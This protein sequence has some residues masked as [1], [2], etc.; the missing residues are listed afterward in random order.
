MS[1][2]TSW[3]RI[4]ARRR[5]PTIMEELAQEYHEKLLD[6]VAEHGRRACMENYLERRGTDH[7]GDQAAAIRKAT[8]AEHDGARRL[9]HLLPQQGRS[10]A[11][12]RHRGLYALSRSTSRPSRASI[13]KTEEED[14]PPG[15]RRRAVLRS[16]LQDHD[17]PLSSA[18]C[19][20]SAFIPAPRQAG[21]TVY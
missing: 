4:S 15:V 2:T 18:S 20:S 5:S 6:A 7:R 3:A 12:G 14:R 13:P 21:S 8:I 1:T 17:R 19:A 11:A 16:G 10:E 9:R